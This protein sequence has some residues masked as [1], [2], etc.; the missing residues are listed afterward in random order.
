ML[1]HLKLDGDH[2]GNSIYFKLCEDEHDREQVAEYW[3]T[4]TACDEIIPKV[5]K[6]VN[7]IV[8]FDGSVVP[9]QLDTIADAIEQ[10]VTYEPSVRPTQLT[11][12]TSAIKEYCAR[13][14]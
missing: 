11:P 9:E 13:K 6:L 5:R 7:K 1:A 10:V 3:R 2:G 12:L 14:S 4:V 8:K